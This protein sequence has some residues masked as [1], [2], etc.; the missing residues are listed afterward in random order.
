MLLL[1]S[2]N[3]QLYS[4]RL[5]TFNVNGKMPSQDLSPWLRPMERDSEKSGWISP[6][7]PIS[8]FEIPSETMGK[9]QSL[10]FAMSLCQ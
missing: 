1:D 9:R 7:K 4:I 6:L 2:F 5:G 3:G 8:P 10:M